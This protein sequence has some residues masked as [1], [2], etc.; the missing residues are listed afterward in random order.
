MIKVL[1]GPSVER[2]I[3]KCMPYT[4]CLHPQHR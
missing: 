4:Q 2:V 1:T 3:Y